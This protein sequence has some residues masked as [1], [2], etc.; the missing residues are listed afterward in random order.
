M[1]GAIATGQE[2]RDDVLATRLRTL[3]AGGED[4]NSPNAKTTEA[5]LP[6]AVSQNAPS[7]PISAVE[8]PAAD[9]QL[10]HDAYLFE[11]DEDHLAD[12]LEGFDEFDLEE[13]GDLVAAGPGRSTGAEE[14]RVSDLLETLKNSPG[15]EKPNYEDD[16]GDDDSDDEHMRRSVH[17]ILAEARDDIEVKSAIPAE[18]DNGFA[19][20][21][22]PGVPSSQPV[23]VPDQ[24]NPKNQDQDTGPRTGRRKSLDFENDITTRLASLRGLGSGV[25]FDS[26]GLPAAPTFRPEDRSATVAAS[27]VRPRGGYTDE[28]QKTWCIVCLD[29]A[30]IRCV[31][32][33]NDV[34][35]SRCFKEMVF[36]PFLPFLRDHCLFHFGCLVVPFQQLEFIDPY[37]GDPPLYVM[38]EG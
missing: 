31:G 19:S 24:T 14:K 8:H 25:N 9:S 10:P 36:F 29:D 13:G 26:F 4:R 2:S 34:Y 37:L 1:A 22:L 11:Q 20:F 12:L 16:V 17:K 30:T 35:C 23:A 27:L 6:H 38:G 5:A 33:D 32:C 21:S 3:R 7:D 18:N 15:L 28:D